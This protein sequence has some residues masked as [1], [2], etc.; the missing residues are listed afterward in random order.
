MGRRSGTSAS[1]EAVG[2][3]FGELHALHFV[4][5]VIA[6]L[7]GYSDGYVRQVL[8]DRGLTQ[9]WND[10]GDVLLALPD[11]LADRCLRLRDKR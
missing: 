3:I 8:D 7:T 4:P 9:R 11:L 5:S 6:R 10:S 2:A 1:K